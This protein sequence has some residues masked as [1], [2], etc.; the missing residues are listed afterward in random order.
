MRAGS[1]HSQTG[2]YPHWECGHLGRR[3]PV[4]SWERGHPGRR[5]FLSLLR[6]GSPHSQ[7][8]SPHSQ[9]GRHPF[10]GGR[11]SWPPP[12]RLLTG[13]AA[14]LAATGSSPHW[15]RGHLG[16]SWFL[17]SLRAGSPHSQWGSP[18][19]QTGLHPHWEGGHLGRRW[20]VSLLRAGSPH[21]QISHLGRIWLVSLLRAGSP[22]SQ[23][24]S[25]HS[26]ISSNWDSTLRAGCLTTETGF[27]LIRFT[28]ATE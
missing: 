10:P 16:R 13:R 2:L 24:G 20:L 7:W 21:S 4:S 6:A 14:I 5:R 18:H 9:T 17:S 22:H 28:V 25:P 23:W 8:G 12:A 27:E 11:P 15:E 1:P 26:Q 3:R 19:S